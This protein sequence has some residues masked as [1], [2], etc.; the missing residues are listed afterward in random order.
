MNV[1]PDSH[2][3]STCPISPHL[4]PSK[5][6]LSVNALDRQMS[7]GSSLRTSFA[8]SGRYVP[9]LAWSSTL[10]GTDSLHRLS[11]SRNTSPNPDPQSQSHPSCENSTS[12]LVR[13][14]SPSS[15]R[16]SS[17]T[18]GCIAEHK[19]FGKE[20]YIRGSGRLFKFDQGESLE[21]VR[22]RATE[23]YAIP[24]TD[25]CSLI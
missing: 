1:S 10:G 15:F 13:H 6:N 23:A 11:R 2:L 5:P 21:D 12:A 25:G 14:L 3:S 18:E 17:L 24:N 20:G 4:A 7:T 22:R 16:A 19:P 9:A 8:L